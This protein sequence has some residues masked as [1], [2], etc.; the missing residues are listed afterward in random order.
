[1]V[2]G[3]PAW[4]RLVAA[5]LAMSTGP[6]TPT[7]RGM[8]VR[9][10]ATTSGAKSA[11]G[12]RT[13]CVA[14]ADSRS[15]GWPSPTTT[16]TSTSSRLRRQR[17]KRAVIGRPAARRLTSGGGT[18]PGMK[19][20]EKAPDFELPDETGAQRKLGDLLA[21]GPVV[22]FFYPAAMTPGCTKESCHFRDLKRE[23]EEVGAQRVGIS[24]DEVDKQKQS[25]DKHT[26][27]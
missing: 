1:M 3:S 10:S 25:A 22:L 4:W 11:V 27:D 24:A 7:W 26:S 20:G 17:A 6:T 16:R 14:R 21:N 18:V 5:A 8:R 23:F 2:T 9:R 19:P 13:T 15:G 12:V